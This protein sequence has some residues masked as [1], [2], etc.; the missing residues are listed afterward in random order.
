M[1]TDMDAQHFRI[2]NL[3][4]SNLILDELP[5]QAA[6]AHKWFNSYSQGTHSF[7]VAQPAFSD[8]SGQ[9]TF[10]QQQ[11]ITRLGRIIVGEWAAT[12]IN[13]SKVPTLDNIRAPLD[14]VTLAHK[15]ITSLGDPIDDQDAV[16][17]H[18]INDIASGLHPKAAVRCATTE[19]ITRGG[20]QDIDGVTLVDND[21]VLVKN[22]G[23]NKF[24]GIWNAHPGSWT[25]AA[26]GDTCSDQETASVFVLEGDTQAN[27]TWFQ[28]T[29]IPSPCNLNTVEFIW[30]LLSRSNT[31][32]AGAGL[33]QSGNTIFAVGTTDRIS[34]GVGI[35]IDAN[36]EGQETIT[37]LGV[38]DTG[39]WEAQVVEGDFG[40]TGV[41]NIGKTITLAG[42]LATVVN[43]IDL[44][45]SFLTFNLL[46]SAL[47]TLPTTGTLATLNG[48][49][50]LTNKHIS[51]DQ[52]DS[53]IVLISH[54]GTSANTATAAIKNLLPDVTGNAGKSLHTDGGDVFY[55]A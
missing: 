14:D 23:A 19:N 32:Q 38:V 12:V 39:A 43:S 9:L 22:Q 54:G 24:N 11:S 1:Q 34:I 4:T 47:L 48:N 44:A 7:G 25:R 52:I 51:G 8:I 26:D 40:G 27:T 16:P 36:Y 20:L 13:P 28:T 18:L 33:D 3:D 31:V 6:Q 45:G 46:G 55:W 30:E 17:L 5:S 50:I 29:P 10:F 37:T 49:E 53:G 2:L 35:D 41:A 42:N 15:R 21:R